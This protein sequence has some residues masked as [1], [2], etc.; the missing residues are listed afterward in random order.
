M[1]PGKGDLSQSHGQLSVLCSCFG[2]SGV[3]GIS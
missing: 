2:L 3:D 1:K